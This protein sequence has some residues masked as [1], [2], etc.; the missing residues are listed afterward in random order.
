M[1]V[2]RRETISDVNLVGGGGMIW[3][4]CPRERERGMFS[5][6][7]TWVRAGVRAIYLEETSS[8]CER[9][10]RERECVC[11]RGREREMD[12]ESVREKDGGR[13]CVKSGL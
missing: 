2:W 8:V 10:V 7:T 12:R 1:C 13:L 9:G 3:H 4:V 11:G 6:G 5:S